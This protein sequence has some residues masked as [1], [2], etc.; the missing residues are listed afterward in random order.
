M[1]PLKF[2][3]LF[4]LLALLAGAFILASKAPT[5]DR[6]WLPEQARTASAI[7]QATSTTIHNV[8]DW[9]YDEAQPL[10]HDWI[11]VTV[12]P[13]D[14]VRVWFLLEPFSALEAIGHT[15]LSFEFEDGTFLSFSVEARRETHETYS[16]LKGQFRAYELSYQWGTE[17]DLITRRLI[18]LDH[19]L[20]LYPLALEKD[21]AR[22]LFVSLLE[23]TTILA[24][25]PRFY[26]TL[27]ANCTNVLATLVNKYYPNTLPYDI[28]WN[29][30]GYAD[31]YLMREGL[32]SVQG[33]Y[34]E[35]IHAHDL[36][37]LR[38]TVRTITTLP[39]PLF[40]TQLRDQMTRPVSEI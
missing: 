35:T 9:T 6:E 31:R 4:A 21:A 5:N 38:D 17:R 32:I 14:V 28:S 10:T 37:P 27:L 33:T 2:I 3:L 11:D 20:R 36:T 25:E 18:Y 24:N 7:I 1:R 26:N 34:E 22:A 40:S 29:L 39:A 19:P 13:S 8:R 23:E 12:D 30:T 16:A 15:F